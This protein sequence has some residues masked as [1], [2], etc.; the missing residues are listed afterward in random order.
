MP[1]APHMSSGF[2]INA[3]SRTLAR[4]QEQDAKR[5][6]PG[7]GQRVLTD[8]L[9]IAQGETIAPLTG[10]LPKR[11]GE[12]SFPGIPRILRSCFYTC[13]PRNVGAIA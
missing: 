2:E 4:N 6:L 12:R 8:D 3:S 5:Y 9:E 10:N 1:I 11:P 7:A 13:E